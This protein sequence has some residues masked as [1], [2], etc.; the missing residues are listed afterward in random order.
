[1]DIPL[2][3]GMY[4]SEGRTSPPLVLRFLRRELTVCFSGPH[5]SVYFEHSWLFTGYI[6]DVLVSSQPLHNLQKLNL[7]GP[8]YRRIRLALFQRLPIRVQQNTIRSHRGF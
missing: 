5:G 3:L 1:M 4:S 2:E 7:A 8:Q 6:P